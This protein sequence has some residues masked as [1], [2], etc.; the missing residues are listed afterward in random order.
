MS[1]HVRMTT[2]L[3]VMVILAGPASAWLAVRDRGWETGWKIAA[4]GLAATLSIAVAGVLERALAG[5]RKRAEEVPAPRGVLDPEQLER[6]RAAALNDVTELRVGAGGQLEKLVR[7]G[8]IEDLRV[9]RVDVERSRVRVS[10]RLLGWS[11]IARRWDRSRGRLVVL[12]D[13]GYGKTVAALTLV[14]HINANAREPGARVAELFR[15]A[16]RQRWR[17][18]HPDEPLAAWLAEQLALTCKARGMSPQFARQL[19]DARLVVPVLDG[20][21]EIANIDARRACV[22][23]IDNYAERG[24]PHRPFVLTCRPHEYE[25][26]APDWVLDDERVVLVG[27]QPDQIRHTLSTSPIA[28]RAGWNAVRER[29]AVGDELINTLFASP[30]YLTIALQVYRDR[31]PSELFQLNAAEARS[32]LWELLLMTMADSYPGATSGQVRGWLAWLAD[33]MRR[34]SRQRFMLHELYELDPQARRNTGSFRLVV[35]LVGGLVVGLGGGHGSGVTGGLVVGLLSGLGGGLGSGLG[36]SPQP[37]VREQ[38]HWKVRLRYMTR[39]D[40]LIA[41]VMTGLL[42]V[43]MSAVTALALGVVSAAITLYAVLGSFLVGATGGIVAAMYGIGTDVTVRDPPPRF[44]HAGPD[45]VLS[46]S[47]SIGIG[48]VRVI[49]KCCG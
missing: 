21:D 19:I 24:E 9:A 15:L 43:L 44:A 26:L 42:C 28:A 22:T 23:A 20:L 7:H 1:A 27:L 14:K 8:D 25:E 11:E 10:G 39:A 6:W 41:A 29:Q 48:I 34:T 49:V 3:P 36:A 35:G 13:P 31:D 12:G 2:A 45:A 38:L 30:L 33:G 4:I 5:R 18:E 40:I 17:G 37:R 46:A 16:D 47:R 32:R